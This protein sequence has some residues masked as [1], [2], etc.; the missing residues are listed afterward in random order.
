MAGNEESSRHE[1][2]E[3]NSIDPENDVNVRI[4]GTI[5]TVNENSF[6]LDD[7][8]AAK[9]VFTQE[10]VSEDLIEEG[11]T[12]RVYGRVLPTPDDYEIEASVVQDMSEVDLE[13]FNKVKKVVSE[14]Q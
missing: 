6:V 12:V 5:V 14:Q 11:S 7:S 4:V 2:K 3:L 8:S 10:N 13:K 1:P 9:E